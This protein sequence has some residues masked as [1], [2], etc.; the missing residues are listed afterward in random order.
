L[1]ENG[2]VLK[3]EIFIES[4]H[5]INESPDPELGLIE[6]INFFFIISFPSLLQLGF[7]FFLFEFHFI[8]EMGFEYS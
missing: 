1:A 6:V 8:E 7:L 4:I 5:L 2:A 3:W